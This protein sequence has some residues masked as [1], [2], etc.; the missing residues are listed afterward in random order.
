MKPMTPM[1]DLWE[2]MQSVFWF[3][4][5][6]FSTWMRFSLF[7]LRIFL[8]FWYGFFWI[9]TFLEF[10]RHFFLDYTVHCKW[11]ALCYISWS[12]VAFSV[13]F[14]EAV[15]ISHNVP[16][17]SFHIDICC[18]HSFLSFL[19]LYFAV[20][21]MYLTSVARSCEVVFEIL[22]SFGFSPVVFIRFS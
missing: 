2:W 20:I 4:C 14:Q 6:D 19:L 11:G 15:V 22:R 7:F 18:F 12:F 16:L 1:A 17:F 9:S 8:W 21:L 3:F 10:W 13:H 5:F